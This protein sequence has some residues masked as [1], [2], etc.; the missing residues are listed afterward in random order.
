MP[1]AS[2]NLCSA[3]PIRIGGEIV[4][5]VVTQVDITERRLLEAERARLLESERAART[6]HVTKPIEPGELLA[7][8]PR[9]RRGQSASDRG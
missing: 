1:R 4:G 9:S 6:D 2:S 7:A 3:A 5:A 8:W